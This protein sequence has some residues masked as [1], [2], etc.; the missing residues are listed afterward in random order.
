MRT[1]VLVTIET[2]EIVETRNI[3]AATDMEVIDIL[4]S[5][6]NEDEEEEGENWRRYELRDGNRL[7]AAW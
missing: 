2:R 4:A 1:Y 6:E 7:V 5:E 3:K